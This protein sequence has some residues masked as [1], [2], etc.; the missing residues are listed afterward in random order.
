MSSRITK[1]VSI[2][3]ELDEFISARVSS[4]RYQSASDVVRD[5]LRLLE[6]FED[7]RQIALQDLRQKILL[8]LEQI[9]GG[10]VHDGESTFEAIGEMARKRRNGVG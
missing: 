2:T 1:N 8:G 4:G 6:E 9:R 7:A 3:P 10:Q 5:A